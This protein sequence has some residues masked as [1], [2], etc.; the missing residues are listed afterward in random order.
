MYTGTT[1]YAVGIL[2]LEMLHSEQTPGEDQYNI[3]R[4][5]KQVTH[6]VNWIELTRN[7]IDWLTN[8]TLYILI[9]YNQT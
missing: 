5:P 9:D 6:T 3:Q 2:V 4:Q 7:V 8:N 1:Y